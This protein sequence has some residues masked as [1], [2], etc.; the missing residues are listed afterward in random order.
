MPLKLG[1]ITAQI[2]NMII[3]QAERPD[4]KDLLNKARTRLRKED[5]AALREHLMAR[6]EAADSRIPWLAALPTESMQGSLADSFAAQMPPA[7]FSVAAADGS[8]IPPDR[9]SPL[10][11]HVINTGQAVLTYG[12][13]PGAILDSAGRLYFEDEELYID[14]S[15]QRIPVDGARL[16]LKMQVQEMQALLDAAGKASRPGVALRDG[17]LIMWPLHSEEKTVQELFLNDFLECLD[18]FRRAD[19]PVASYISYS[20]GQD[21]VN[22]LRVRLCPLKSPDCPNC[23]MGDADRE[24][25]AFLSTLRDRQLFFDDSLLA[26]GKRSQVFASSSAILDKYREHRIRFFYLNVG[27]EIARVEAPAWVTED[28]AMLNRLHAAIMDQCRRSGNYPPYPPVLM[29]A[30]EQAVITTTERRLVEE[31]VEQEMAGRR[32]IY[33]R[34]AKDR[35]KRTRAV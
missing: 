4:W 11:Y 16:G 28:E 31:I 5:P 27:G 24:L 21:V 9:H 12:A 22:A 19:F 30:H 3:S 14:A 15:S 17:S 7:N 34:S 13:R 8:A 23:P 20:G 18:E 29:E 35:S 2:Q 32:Q 1:P 6:A 25:C 33:L 26:K 10:Q